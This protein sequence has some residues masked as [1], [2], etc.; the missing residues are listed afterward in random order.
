MKPTSDLIDELYREDIRDGQRMPPE[1]KLL[2]GARL[3]DYASRI[4]K[5]GLRNRHPGASEA[6]IHRLFLERLELADRLEGRE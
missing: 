2:E 1:Q 3:F 4:V 5:D 6:E